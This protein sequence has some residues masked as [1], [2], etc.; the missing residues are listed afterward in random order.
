[1]PNVIA[2]L[3]N[4]AQQ[5][6][7]SFTTFSGTLYYCR[8]LSNTKSVLHLCYLCSRKKTDVTCCS[9]SSYPSQ[10]IIFMS[11]V[12]I[13]NYSYT[14]RQPGSTSGLRLALFVD[15]ANYLHAY[16][17]S[18]GFRVSKLY[19]TSNLRREGLPHHPT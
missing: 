19:F 4:N 11:D 1:V 9:S 3:S 8:H 7:N 10:S 2:L 18:T 15:Q 16:S 6:A 12:C 5:M 13:E 14:S 17:A